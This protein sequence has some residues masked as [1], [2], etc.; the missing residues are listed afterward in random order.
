MFQSYR[1]ERCYCFVVALDNIG[2]GSA[3]HAHIVTEQGGIEVLQHCADAYRGQ[4][5]NSE[6]VM[7]AESAIITMYMHIEIRA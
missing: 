3:E 1:A 7:N 2:T 5:G 4:G 6:I